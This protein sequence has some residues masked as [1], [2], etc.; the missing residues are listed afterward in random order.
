M[1]EFSPLP[2]LPLTTESDD[3]SKIKARTCKPWFVLLIWR[4]IIELN[5]KGENATLS[6]IS[7]IMTKRL[8]MAR[9][10]KKVKSALNDGLIA[11][12]S[13]VYSITESDVG[14]FHEWYYRIQSVIRKKKLEKKDISEVLHLI[15]QNVKSKFGSI[16]EKSEL[17]NENELLVKHLP[18]LLCHPRFNF[19]NV[20][21]KIKNDNYESLFEFEKDCK[22]IDYNLSVL[23]RPRSEISKESKRMCEFVKQQIENVNYCVECFVRQNDTNCKDWFSEACNPPHK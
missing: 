14:L 20:E 2:K 23:Y 5:K 16:V 11:K 6:A 1:T 13:E 21:G 10:E 9:L 12:S 19:S 4:L 8:S 3:S 7:K 18:K 22:T 17:K 15:L